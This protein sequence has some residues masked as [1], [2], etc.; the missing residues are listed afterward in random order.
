M[1][2]RS[3]LGSTETGFR[4]FGDT[5]NAVVVDTVITNAMTVDVEDYFQVSAFDDNVLRDDWETYPL[6]V[7]RNVETILALFADH[8]VRATFFVLGWVAERQPELVKRMAAA[9]HEIASHGY[10]HKRVHHQS[11]V[12]FRSD[13]GRARKLLED[14]TGISVRGYRAPSFSINGNT[15]WAFEIL[16][17]EGYA[18]SSSIYPIRHDHYGMPEAPRFPFRPLRD[19]ALMEIPIT[20]FALGGINLPCGGG[21]Y[22]RLLPS[23]FCHWGLQRVNEKER[24][25]GVF[26]FHPW[27]IDPDQP[28]IDG[29]SVKARL[30]HYT[31]L[32][33]MRKKLEKTLSRFSWD[34]V[35]HVFGLGGNGE[36]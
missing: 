27:E 14:I 31:N 22:F 4:V 7:G 23:N 36:R 13:V 2:W 26:Y 19:S 10:A 3:H 6:R 12:Q 20:T 33:H 17:E 15:P 21:G 24:K 8:R 32:K 35:D 5:G 29:A 25:P 11:P 1:P 9:G 34:R 28:R 30:R 18:Y 16:A